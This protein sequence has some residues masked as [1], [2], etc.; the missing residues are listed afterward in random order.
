MSDL[1]GARITAEQRDRA[2]R[3]LADHLG[4]G[5]LTLTEYDERA[6]AVAAA[7]TTPDLAAVF[8]DLPV[9]VPPPAPRQATDPALVYALTA[10]GA[11]ALALVLA[12]V[13]GGWLWLVLLVLALI[14]APPVASVVRRVSRRP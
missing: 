12:L 4:S 7:S 9:A 10:G 6:T 8:T 11:A 2:L 13:F 14:A 5:R 3:E 1:S